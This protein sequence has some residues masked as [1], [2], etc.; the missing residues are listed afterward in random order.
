M[1][2]G[3]L[4]KHG[5]RRGSTYRTN[6]GR[7]FIGSEGDRLWL[8]MDGVQVRSNLEPVDLM[9]MVGTFIILSWR[10]IEVAGK[11]GVFIG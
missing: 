5:L 2:T 4:R 9:T 3:H 1:E 7:Q 6:D 8:R 10:D 11:G